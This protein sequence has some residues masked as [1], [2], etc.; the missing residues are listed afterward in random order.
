MNNQYYGVYLRVVSKQGKCVFEAKCNKLIHMMAI[1][2]AF[3]RFSQKMDMPK[4]LPINLKWNSNFTND[5]QDQ[6]ILFRWRIDDHLDSKYLYSGIIKVFQDDE[7]P[8]TTMSFGD[9]RLASINFEG[10]SEKVIDR[11][12]AWTGEDWNLGLTL[13]LFASQIPTHPFWSE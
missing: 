1:N 5:I 10:I 12:V 8:E 6:T 7:P 9:T 2:L 3:F 13:L 11:F 4:N